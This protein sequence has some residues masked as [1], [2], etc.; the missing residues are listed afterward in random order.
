M[1]PSIIVLLVA[2]VVGSFAVVAGGFL[3]VRSLRKEL[4]KTRADAEH[5]LRQCQD[6]DKNLSYEKSISEVAI[7]QNEDLRRTLNRLE[8]DYEEKFKSWQSIAEKKIRKDAVGR[9]RRVRKGL[10]SEHLVP[11]LQERFEASDMRFLG[12]PVDYLICCGSTGIKSK[13][14]DR[15]E[16]VVLLDVKTGKAGLN[17]TQRRIRDAITDGRVRFATYNPGTGFR[18]WPESYP[19]ED[20]E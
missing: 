10:S 11:H 8:S 4:E 1:S 9:S 5:W 19:E 15:I 16:E 13:T 18:F 12:E 17:K 20:T 7:S 14:V 2:I 6:V 3:E